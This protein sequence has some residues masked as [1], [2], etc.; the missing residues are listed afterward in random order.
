[1]MKPWVLSA[2][3]LA[4]PG[5]ESGPKVV[6]PAQPSGQALQ[7]DLPSPEGFVS[8]ENAVNRN[9]TGAW[10]VVN[11]TLEGKNRRIEGAAQFFREAW[12]KHGWT[13]EESKGDPKNG[14][15]TLVFSNRNERA[16]LEIKDATRE[17]VMIK[18]HVD[19]KD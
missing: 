18:L 14:P 11:Q 4:L 10:R 19:K 2:L 5:C 6:T 16:R 13:L 17:M 15:L 8:T 12:P 1:M 3:L 7:P 9:P